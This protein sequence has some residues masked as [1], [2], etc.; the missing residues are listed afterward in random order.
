MKEQENWKSNNISDWLDTFHHKE[1]N[2]I[3]QSDLE[4][5]W[6]KHREEKATLETEIYRLKKLRIA[7][8][9]QTGTAATN[10]FIQPAN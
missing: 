2:V 3:Q 8:D 5:S 10:V 4:Q 7:K 9:E 1:P 6:R